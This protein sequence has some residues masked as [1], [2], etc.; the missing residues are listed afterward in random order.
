MRFASRHDAGQKLGRRLLDEGAEVD[1]V[2]GLPRGGVI[3]AADVARV[4]QRPLD[5]L[6]V[7][8]I[9]H[10]LH[11]EF[12]VGAMAENDVVLLDEHNISSDALLLQKLGEVMEEEKLR[13]QHYQSKFHEAGK[14]DF[15]D[16]SVLL[17]DDGLATG[18]TME[19]AV[20]SARK[21]GARQILVA[22]PVASASAILR[23]ERVADDLFIVIMDPGFESVGSYYEAFSQ[24]EDEE[25][26]NVLK[27]DHV[28]H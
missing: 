21:Q 25:V 5:I 20:L 17:V 22:A 14:F 2:V 7:R 16:K 11:R 15:R 27:A 23:L 3:V 18:A 26:L 12:A 13:F 1:I 28:N 4:L 19:A 24:T 6:V 8:K 9:G 10:P